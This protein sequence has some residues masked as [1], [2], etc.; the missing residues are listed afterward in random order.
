MVVTF[1]HSTSFTEECHRLTIIHA[2]HFVIFL[3]TRGTN[4]VKFL[5]SDDINIRP[6]VKVELD[7]YAVNGNFN[8]Q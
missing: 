6:I 7:L 2:C 1:L 3:K 8:L 4:V 5:F